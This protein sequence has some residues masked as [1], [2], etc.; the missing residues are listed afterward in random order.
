MPIRCPITTGSKPYVWATPAQLQQWRVNW[1][2]E[3]AA[4]KEAHREEVESLVAK[5]EAQ[6]KEARA[7]NV[8]SGVKTA[9]PAP[10]H[11]LVLRSKATATM[12]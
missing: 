11:G 9:Q 12:S 3:K 1:R 10:V 6:L 4:L 5:F 7:E 8:A 2:E